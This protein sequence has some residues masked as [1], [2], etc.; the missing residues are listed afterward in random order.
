MYPTRLN[1]LP[2]EKRKF[3]QKMIYIQFIK[4]VFISIV[5]V[6]CVSGILLLGAQSILQEYLN[7]VSSNLIATRSSHTG[8][9]RAIKDI[10]KILLETEA[11]QQLYIPWTST[12]I[13]MA[14]STPN[15][16]TL[17]N[18]SLDSKTK[19]HVISGTADT[20]EDLLTFQENLETLDFIDQVEI[21][22]S[23]LTEKENISFSI[24]A[25]SK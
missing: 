14:N 20:R 17:N 8:K 6:F 16:I 11:V 2:P 5:F 25:I 10:N 1:L 24:S 15:G 22:P 7:D 19:T 9:N 3:L 13:D 4:N 23:Q 21:P 12:I 18:L